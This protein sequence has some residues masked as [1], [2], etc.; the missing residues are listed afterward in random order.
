MFLGPGPSFELRLG[1]EQYGQRRKIDSPRGTLVTQQRLA[2][3]GNRY[4]LYGRYLLCQTCDL[5]PVL[6]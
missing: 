3:V 5:F 6:I 4:A 2:A 1:R